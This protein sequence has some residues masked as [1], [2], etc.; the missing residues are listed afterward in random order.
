MSK[1][2][3][4]NRNIIHSHS[5]SIF[6]YYCIQYRRKFE[7]VSFYVKYNH[8]PISLFYLFKNDL[9]VY[10]QSIRIRYE[11]DIF[12]STDVGESCHEYNEFLVL[13]CTEIYWWKH[14][15][16]CVLKIMISCLMVQWMNSSHKSKQ[17]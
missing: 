8:S 9:L 12:A 16:I 3:T 11:P 7:M 14:R 17:K 4:K 5:Q 2:C 1:C 10:K 15:W 13:F 6:L